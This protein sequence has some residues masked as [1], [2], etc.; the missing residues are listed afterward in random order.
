MAINLLYQ[1]LISSSRMHITIIE[2][3]GYCL[4]TL[5]RL[6]LVSKSSLPTLCAILLLL[7]KINNQTVKM[8]ALR[9]YAELSDTND[10]KIM[11]LLTATLSAY[12]LCCSGTAL[13]EVCRYWGCG[14]ISWHLTS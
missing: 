7:I 11:T 4:E 1:M 3:V 9:I 2:T 5:H 6:E 12:A 14:P 13:E 10:E 8:I